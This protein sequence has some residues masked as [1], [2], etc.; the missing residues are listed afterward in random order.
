MKSKNISSRTVCTIYTFFFLLIIGISI[1]TSYSQQKIQFNG[2]ETYQDS[3]IFLGNLFL[4][5]MKNKQFEE[6][7]YLLSDRILFRALIPSSLVT[8]NDPV[9]I[10]KRFKNWFYVESPNKYEVIDSDVSFL[11]DCIHIYYKIFET[12][13]GNPYHVEQHLYCEISSGKINK[14]SLVCSGFRKIAE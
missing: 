8:S 1:K 2:C 7:Q 3:S 12:Y 14:I 5:K 4:K 11:V 6:I 9:E 13:K 10:A